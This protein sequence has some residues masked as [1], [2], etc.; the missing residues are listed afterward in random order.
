MLQIREPNDCVVATGRTASIEAF[1]RLAF[2]H[3]RL[4]WR[5]HFN[6]DESLMRRAGPVRERLPVKIDLG[7]APRK[8]FGPLAVMM[9]DT[10]FAKVSS[11]S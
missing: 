11:E 4:D 10:D 8:A 2:A 5:D 9:V 6:V 3:A 7:W 1:C